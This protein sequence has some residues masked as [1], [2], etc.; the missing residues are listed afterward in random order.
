MTTPLHPADAER[1]ESLEFFLKDAA[2]DLE[3]AL[4]RAAVIADTV[5]KCRLKHSKVLQVRDSFKSALQGMGC[6]TKS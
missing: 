3:L 4:Q 1:L 5:E 6:E 2:E